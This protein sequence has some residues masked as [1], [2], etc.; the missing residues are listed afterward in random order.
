MKYLVFILTF[1]ISTCLTAQNGSITGKVIDESTGEDLIGAIVQIEG[2]QMGAATDFS[3]VY[4][5][6]NVS[7]GTYSLQIGY[8]SYQSKKVVGVVVEPGKTVTIDIALG[9]APLEETG[10]VEIVESRVTSTEASVLME[11]KE[12]KGV[13][14][15]IGAAQIAKSQDRDA[16][17]VAR[18]IPGVTV[19]DSRF[20]IVRGL[21]ERYNAVMINNA[22]APSMETDVKSFSFDIISSGLIDRFLV[23]KSPS[24]DL[25]GEF[26]GGAIKV[27]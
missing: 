13:L 25:P 15:G 21:S 6:K 16:S 17:E 18:R 8:I 9:T 19:V 26:A 24:P 7:P 27:F 14:S 23:Y 10:V 5:I 4:H 1:L 22:L 20:V 3:G 2:T 12:A 11:M